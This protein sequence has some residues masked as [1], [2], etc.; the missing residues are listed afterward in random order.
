MFV[1]CKIWWSIFSL[2]TSKWQWI[3]KVNELTSPKKHRR[4]KRFKLIVLAEKFIVQCPHIYLNVL[5]INV[6]SCI[7]IIVSPMGPT[8]IEWYNQIII[9]KKIHECW[10]KCFFWDLNDSWFLLEEGQ[11]Y[12]WLWFSTTVSELKMTQYSWWLAPGSR[13]G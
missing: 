3:L 7:I 13:L 2:P 9:K 12:N 4:F 1:K 10:N 8:S 5:S 11:S 6:F